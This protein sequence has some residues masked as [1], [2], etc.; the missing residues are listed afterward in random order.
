MSI[1]RVVNGVLSLGQSNLARRGSNRELLL[2]ETRVLS[3]LFLVKWFLELV[4]K[5]LQTLGV[6]NPGP[7]WTRTGRWIIARWCNLGVE[8]QSLFELNAL[9]QISI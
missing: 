3:V 6:L 4:Q 9:P 2:D 1:P 5:H 7:R 8:D